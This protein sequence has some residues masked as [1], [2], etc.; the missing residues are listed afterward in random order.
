MQTCWLAGGCSTC[1]ENWGLRSSAS[2]RQ[3]MHCLEAP[4]PPSIC[5]RRS[6]SVNTE[7]TCVPVLLLTRDA[8]SAPWETEASWAG[9]RLQRRALPLSSPWGREPWE[10]RWRPP[11]KRRRQSPPPPRLHLPAPL[12]S[13]ELLVP[14]ATAPHLSSDDHLNGKGSEL[15]SAVRERGMRRSSC[16]SR[17]LVLQV[18]LRR[19]PREESASTA[20]HLRLLRPKY[21]LTSL[22]TLEQIFI[23]NTTKGSHQEL[24]VTDNRVALLKLHICSFIAIVLLYCHFRLSTIILLHSHL[25]LSTIIFLLLL[26]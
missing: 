16:S 19:R 23:I 4:N 5:I 13:D 9:T 25:R 6:E 3:G 8:K 17:G 10:L 11:D 2:L 18:E 7:T 1:D 22:Y 12:H 15:L 14:T 21:Y 20:A 26:P 24:R